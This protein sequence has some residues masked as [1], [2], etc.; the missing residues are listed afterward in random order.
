MSTK[1]V[2]IE[3]WQAKLHAYVVNLNMDTIHLYAPT[4]KTVAN[5]F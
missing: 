3:R 5:K 2:I 1:R 4:Q